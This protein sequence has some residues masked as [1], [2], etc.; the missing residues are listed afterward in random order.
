MNKQND[1]IL[2]EL[3]AHGGN[4][5]AVARALGIDYHALKTRFPQQYAPLKTPTGPEPSDIRTLGKPALSAYV[6]AV[7]KAGH[8]WPEKYDA[9]IA[10][11]R[12]KFD[13]GT[14]EMFQSNNEGWVVQYLVPHLIP[15]PKRQFFSTMIVMR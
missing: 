4:I 14:H 12:L 2:E 15:Q 3:K 9:A 1:Q 8:A 7:K 5:S 11:A 6:I 13:A 10:D